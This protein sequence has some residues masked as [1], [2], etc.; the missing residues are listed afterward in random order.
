MLDIDMKKTGKTSCLIGI[1]IENR[2][3]NKQNQITS[4]CNYH[5]NIAIGHETK[6]C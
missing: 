4:E 6:L 3:N 5:E 1:L 2:N